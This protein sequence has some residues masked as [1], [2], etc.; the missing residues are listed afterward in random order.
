VAKKRLHKKNRRAK[1]PLSNLH[2]R[3]DRSKVKKFLATHFV[4]LTALVITVLTSF[5]IYFLAYSE[6]DIRFSKSTNLLN[7]NNAIK[8]KDGNCLY[9]AAIKQSF[10]NLSMRSGYI[11]DVKIIAE[12]LEVLSECKLV[13]VDKSKFQWREE[14]EI[15][16]KFDLILD[17]S[18]CKEWQQDEELFLQIKYFDNTG[19]LL[20][21]NVDGNQVGLDNGW[22]VLLNPSSD[23]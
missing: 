16:T 5:V 6:P 15:E 2:V 22:I 17:S 9:R 19:K 10:K 23:N 18:T 1:K 7:M 21:R 12:N 8:T 3:I 13:D 4:S 11:N 14:R 20:E